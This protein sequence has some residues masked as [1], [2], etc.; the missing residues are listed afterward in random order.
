M[1]PLNVV[2][3]IRQYAGKA[4]TLRN[5]TRTER[6][7]NSLPA[8][9]RKDIGWPD[10][11]RRAHMIARRRMCLPEQEPARG[12]TP[13]GAAVHIGMDQA[14]LLTERCQEDHDRD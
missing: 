13:E 1:N 12:A 11:L 4:Q 14:R 8:H 6:L 5:Q 2:R 9:L 7:L 10:R 3:S